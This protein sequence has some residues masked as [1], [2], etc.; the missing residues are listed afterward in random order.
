LA[1]LVAQLLHLLEQLGLDKPLILFITFLD[2]VS[3]LTSQYEA[4]KR[5]MQYSVD[6]K[7]MHAHGLHHGVAL[8]ACVVALKWI[9]HDRL[10]L[11]LSL[12]LTHCAILSERA[13]A[14]LHFL[15]DAELL[16]LHHFFTIH[17]IGGLPL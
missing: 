8:G 14:F 3:H 16:P 15:N 4:V 11:F 7:S 9:E 13:I 1:E 2:E 10:S 12:D 5:A 6:S 17:A